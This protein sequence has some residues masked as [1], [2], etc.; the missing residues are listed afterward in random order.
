[1]IKISKLLLT[2]LIIFVVLPT[3][4][5][6][7]ENVIILRLDVYRNDTLNLLDIYVDEGVESLELFNDAL[8]YKIEFKSSDDDV[9]YSK[10]FQSSFEIIFD[11]LPGESPPY[12]GS[13]LLDSFSVVLKLK[14]F[15]NI[16]RVN[17]YHI[18]KKIFSKEII[19]CNNNNECE[20]NLNE[21]L[22]SCPSDCKSGSSDNYCDAILDGVCDID[23]VE[24]GRIEK[25]IDC[26]C[27]NDICDVRENQKTCSLDCKISFY[28]RIIEWLKS[29]FN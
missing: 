22:L 17:I 27:G 28:Q 3:S 9:I 14:Y 1:M 29:I 6:A 23:C 26:T 18:D 5:I 11:P 7:V 19:F 13:I 12:N 8:D 24:Q 20:Q 4:V 16:S 10:Y 25:D 21:N 15:N 2:I